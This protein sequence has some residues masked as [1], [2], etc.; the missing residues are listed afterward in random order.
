MTAAQRR[1]LFA[2]ASALGMDDGERHEF[3]EMFLKVDEP[4]WGGL[5]EVQAARLI[6][7]LEGFVLMTQLLNQRPPRR[8]SHDDPC[9]VCHVKAGELCR[10]NSSPLRTRTLHLCG[11]P[12]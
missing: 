5:N 11:W 6:D 7:A 3:T 9:P 12:R 10:D 8:P 4:S 1:R 2:V